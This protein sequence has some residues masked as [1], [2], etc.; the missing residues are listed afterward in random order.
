MCQSI[1]A[2]ADARKAEVSGDHCI[3]YR[4]SRSRMSGSPKTANEVGQKAGGDLDADVIGH[5][6]TVVRIGPAQV[7]VD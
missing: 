4:P 1:S 3:G 2:V 5:G 6:R 7:A